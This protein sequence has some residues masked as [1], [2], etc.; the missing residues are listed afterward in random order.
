MKPAFIFILFGT[1][2]FIWFMYEKIKKYGRK[3]TIIKAA[4]S[5]F[6]VFTAVASCFQN[7]VDRNTICLKVFVIAG[8]V[9]GVFGDF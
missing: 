1:I 8:L 4:A 2:L 6:F 5:C 3:E 7:A 9:A